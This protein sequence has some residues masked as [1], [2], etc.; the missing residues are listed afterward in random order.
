MYYKYGCIKQ[1]AGYEKRR[2]KKYH[3]SGWRYY[4]SY[5][6]G[7]KYGRILP[8]TSYVFYTNQAWGML[9]KCWLGYK[10]SKSTDD[11]KKMEY[12]AEG[13]RKAQKELKLPIDS[14]PNL[15]IDDDTGNSR[16]GPELGDTLNEYDDESYGYESEAQREWRERMDYESPAQRAWRERIQKYYYKI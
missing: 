5:Y 4:D 11:F 16:M 3:S 8:E 2:P 12:Y 9:Q 7:S 1:I 15:D 14:F 13:I 10:I 6:R